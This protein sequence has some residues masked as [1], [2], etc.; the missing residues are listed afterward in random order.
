[1]AERVKHK[2]SSSPL[3]C[4]LPTG[5][6]PSELPTAVTEPPAVIAKTAASAFDSHTL[7]TS[8]VRG[9]AFN[10]SLYECFLI[11]PRTLF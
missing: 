5:S 7:S 11:H 1:M 6:S 3:S 2:S 9:S 10:V 4:P 8:S